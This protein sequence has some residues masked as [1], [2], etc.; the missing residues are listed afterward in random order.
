MG[1]KVALNLAARQCFFTGGLAGFGRIDI[2]YFEK[3]RP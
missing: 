3:Y 2:I 1:H